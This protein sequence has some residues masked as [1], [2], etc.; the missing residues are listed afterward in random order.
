MPAYWFWVPACALLV[1]A[2]KSEEP[3][4]TRES[5]S[6]EPSSIHTDYLDDLVP[7]TNGGAYAVGLDGMWYLRGATAVR[8][9]A[10]GDSASRAEFA[11]ALSMDVQPTVD[12]GAYAVSLGGGIWRVEADSAVRVVEADSLPADTAA[13][14]APSAMLGWSLYAKERRLRENGEKDGGGAEIPYDEA[15][16]SP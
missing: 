12:G 11:S 14:P 3:A 16:Q 13:V 9:R 10:L 6:R 15:E 1:A 4:R 5:R 7:L 8:V 2:C